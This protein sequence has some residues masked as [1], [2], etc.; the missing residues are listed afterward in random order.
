[1][2]I[3]IAIYFPKAIVEWFDLT[4]ADVLR[5]QY[6]ALILPIVAFALNLLIKMNGDIILPSFRNKQFSV[7]FTQ[8][9]FIFIALVVLFLDDVL[10]QYLSLSLMKEWFG[11]AESQKVI[12]GVL[13]L[14]EFF[15]LSAAL[16]FVSEIGSWL[17]LLIF[18]KTKRIPDISGN[19]N[20]ISAL[21]LVLMA[22]SLI[23]LLNAISFAL[24]AFVLYYNYCM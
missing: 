15:A 6:I 17:H 22:H 7:L 20:Q 23:P 10:R 24:S 9:K 3:D 8:M 16:S 2:F 4:A 14:I 11:V 21:A 18:K 13:C 1:M 5:L 12:T 19:N